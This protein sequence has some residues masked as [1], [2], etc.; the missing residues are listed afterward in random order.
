M[1]RR[2]QTLTKL[3]IQE[4]V[5]AQQQQEKLRLHNQLAQVQKDGRKRLT[6]LTMQS[7]NAAKKLQTVIAKVNHLTPGLPTVHTYACPSFHCIFTVWL[8]RER[9]FYSL[10]KYVRH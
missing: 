1:S 7:N 4:D 6:N 3:L 2:K 9:G 10:V 8:C 5:R